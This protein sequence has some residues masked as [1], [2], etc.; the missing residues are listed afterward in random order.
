MA[1]RRRSLK[2]IYN[3][4][5][6]PTEV[7]AINQDPGEQHDIAATLPRRTIDEAEMDMLVWRE[8]VSQPF[9]APHSNNAVH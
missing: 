2:F 6:S 8:R 1:V 5:R 4:D 9:V 3:F 7:Y